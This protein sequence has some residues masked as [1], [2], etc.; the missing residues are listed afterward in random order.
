MNE[1]FVWRYPGQPWSA[2][3]DD[4]LW[5]L[6]A[7]DKSSI[8]SGDSGARAGVRNIQHCP[9][10]KTSQFVAFK[11]ISTL[12]NEDTSILEFP[13]CNG[14]NVLGANIVTSPQ[15]VQMSPEPS[16]NW[17]THIRN[18]C[19]SRCLNLDNFRAAVCDV[20]TLFAL[21][22]TISQDDS[23][24]LSLIMSLLVSWWSWYRHTEKTEDTTKIWETLMS[25]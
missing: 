7:A 4:V 6:V 13:G 22:M 2:V 23:Q 8:S 1:D 9:E 21:W 5:H 12:C 18:S 24:D 19:R 11:P 15:C 14:G 20:Y 25:T 10:L 17:R 16:I 3:S